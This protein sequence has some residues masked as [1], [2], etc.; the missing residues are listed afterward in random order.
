MTDFKVQTLDGAVD[1]PA[2]TYVDDPDTGFY[3]IGA[4]NVGLSIGGVKK[5]DFGAAAWEI[6]P[7][8]TLLN[9]LKADAIDEATPGSGVT[10][11]SLLIKD[12]S[13]PNWTGSGAL[14]TLGTIGTGVWEGTT[15][16]VDQGG[17][18]LTTV[19]EGDLLYADGADSL[20]ALA[21]G[22]NDKVLGVSGGA[23][24]WVDQSGGGGAIT[25]ADVGAGTFPAG[26]FIFTD[27][28]NVNGVTVGSGNNEEYRNTV[29]GGGALNNDNGG[30]A[31]TAVGYQTLQGVVTGNS[32]TAVGFRALQDVTS[33]Y[34]NAGMGANS[35]KQLTT[36]ANN[37]A[38]GTSALGTG[39][40]CN[41]N[42]AIG[43]STLTVATG[44]GN[45]AFGYQA[46]M[47]LTTGSQ[48][49][50]IGYD[51]GN[52]ASQLVTA[53]NS[54]GI[55]YAA[56][57]DASN[58]VVL[59]N[60][61][62]TEV[63]FRSD[64]AKLVFGAAGDTNLYRGAA[65]VLATDDALK[66]LGDIWIW[67]GLAA[68]ANSL[69][70][71]TGAL[72]GTTTGIYNMALGVNALS[73]CTE[74]DRNVA[75]GAYTL[76]VLTTG[77]FNTA[78]GQGALGALTTG[79]YNV[80]I[81]YQTL[82]AIT[83]ANGRIAIGYQAMQNVVDAAGRT[84]AVGYQAMSGGAVESDDNHAFG[85][86]ALQDLTT[87]AR[88]TA[89]GSYAATNLTEANNST[90]IGYKA[91]GTGI[92]TGD[93]NTAIGYQAM[94]DVTSGF[95]N[96]AMGYGASANLTT[97]SNNVAVGYN[98]MGLGVVT[99]SS[100][101]GIG[102]SALYD[103]TDGDYNVGIGLSALGE[104]TTG[105]NNIALGRDALDS[106]TEGGSNV[107]LGYLALGSNVTGKNNIAVGVQS[108]EAISATGVVGVGHNAGRTLTSGNYNTFLGYYAGF[109]AVNQKVDA[110]DSTAIGAHSYTDASYQVALGGSTITEV[111]I[112]ANAA[113]LVFG[114][115]GDTNLY[116][117]AADVLKTD[118]ALEVVGA[119]G[120]N[121]ASPQTAYASG[122]ALAAYGAGANGLDSGAN[123]SALHAMVVAMRAA[124]V[125]NGIM[126]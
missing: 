104:C 65:D 68:D 61:S 102:P 91:M 105:G 87:G 34:N 18:G 23:L 55:G 26:A 111:R 64:S 43:T 36:G 50:F 4:D 53:A 42:V 121:A 99:G 89:I 67:K 8:L 93:N 54:T 100:N 31:L 7:L 51:A 58:Q 88:N 1:A 96:F 81:G 71:G 94:D 5:G 9:G 123:M 106:L 72:D 90:A 45:A 59:G 2:Y 24:A 57:T 108:F 75:V 47:D 6:T 3:R 70:V 97:G 80:A 11:D 49:V 78:V 20:A 122:G 37:L 125:A 110:I 33:G 39:T 14:T 13:L 63:R 46:G 32:N 82:Q 73:A 41:N 19:T 29:L 101:V 119:F 40:D 60:L 66:V 83:T 15:V 126:S 48:N 79:D 38:I 98:A 103:L 84:M 28:I 85:Y 62:I 116:R 74:G 77:S 120:C 86:Q 124:L 56:Y 17:T 114:A 115:A 107:A 30:Y 112:R 76:D 10:V 109:D 117:G 113:K 69:G 92:A 95:R 16:A 21:I 35:G 22:A 52:Q 44:D 118:D 25:A 27:D 12:G